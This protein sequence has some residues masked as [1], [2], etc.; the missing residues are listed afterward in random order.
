VTATEALRFLNS[1]IDNWRPFF[2]HVSF[3]SP[4]NPFDPP[5]RWFERHLPAQMPVPVG[6]S[7]A[8]RAAFWRHETARYAGMVEY[9]DH[10]IGRILDDLDRLKLVEETLVLFTTDHGEMLGHRN[11]AGK[12]RPEEA[13]IRTPVFARLPGTIPAGRTL[14]DPAEAVDLPC[15]ILDAMGVDYDRELPETPGRSY[16]GYLIGASDSHRLWSYTE[17]GGT[18]M[19][20]VIRDSR[21]KYVFRPNGEDA[22]Y[23]VQ[24]DPWEQ[25]NRIADPPEASRVARMRH[26]LCDSSARC[27]PPNRDVRRHATAH[28]HQAEKGQL[29]KRLRSEKPPEQGCV[30]T[31]AKK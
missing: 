4:H 13:S 9:V 20:R 21:W 3:C 15:T 28:E 29:E 31:G 14:S 19:F 27:V 8:E 26:M 12:C 7:S 24:A 11:R 30:M 5:Q 6:D 25:D 16:W 18:D 23:D 1:G 10:Q 17:Y 2:L 22:L